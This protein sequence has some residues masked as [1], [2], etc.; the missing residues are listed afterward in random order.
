MTKDALVITGPTAAGK[1]ALSLAVA[2]QLRGEIISFDSRQLYRGLDIGTAKATPAEQ[3]RVPHH[4]LDLV[5]PGER[6]S[7]GRFARAAHRWI[8]EIR[9][10][11]HLPILVGGTGFFLHA[12]IN[13]LFAEPELEP[14]RREQLEHFLDRQPPELLRAWLARLDPETAAVLEQGGGRQRLTR[15]L[16]IALLTGRPLSWWHRN[17]PAETTPL[18]PLVF[19][20]NLPR[21]ELDRRIDERVSAMLDAG[22]VAE[23]EGLLAAGLRPG[24][25]GLNATGYPEIIAYLQGEY[26]LDEAADAIRRATRRYARRQLT[27]FRHQL[28]GAIWLDASLPTLTLVDMIVRSWTEEAP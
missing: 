20:V 15:A 11:G 10:R 13:P 27:W 18:R 2:E 23:V 22:L 25:P 14:T 24:D 4:G 9:A 28:P 7:A 3:A 5:D 26:S 12:L 6:Y 17:A 19:I 1:T 21:E 16:E 8:H